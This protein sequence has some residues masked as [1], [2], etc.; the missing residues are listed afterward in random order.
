MAFTYLFLAL[1]ISSAPVLELRY[2]NSVDRAMARLRDMS[3]SKIVSDL[4]QQYSLILGKKDA[5]DD[6]L[7]RL[8][9]A[10]LGQWWY[11]ATPNSSRQKEKI[12]VWIGTHI[13]QLKA[14]AEKE[15]IYSLVVTYPERIHPREY[16]DM[17]LKDSAVVSM[18][19]LNAWNWRFAKSEKDILRIQSAVDSARKVKRSKYFEPHC[20]AI[21]S[22]NCYMFRKDFKALKNFVEYQYASARLDPNPKALQQSREFLKPWED[23]LKK[24]GF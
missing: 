16:G 24:K 23:M 21:F 9:C 1:Q 4:E 6:E 10:Y 11:F 7:I 3:E 13:G 15:A 17:A 20:Q 8:S 19:A 14:S 2:G 18:A 5:S 22:F 12:K